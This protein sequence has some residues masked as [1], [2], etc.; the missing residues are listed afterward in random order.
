M[1]ILRKIIACT[2]KNYIN[3][4]QAVYV[5]NI[6][7]MYKDKIIAP[8]EFLLERERGYPLININNFCNHQYLGVFLFVQFILGH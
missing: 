7:H 5:R 2:S 6:I 3:Y 4:I 8:H 1:I